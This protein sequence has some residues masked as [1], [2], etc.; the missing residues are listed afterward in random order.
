MY[1]VSY[2]GFTQWCA[3]VKQPPAL[4]AIVPFETWAEPTNGLAFRGGALELGVNA[5][6]G[7]QMG[8]D[9]LVRRHRSDSRALGPAIVALSK[10]I[11]QLATEGYSSL[12]LAE[13]GPF[14]RQPMLPR[15]FETVARPMDAELLIAL[16]SEHGPTSGYMQRIRESL[17]RDFPGSSFAHAG[18]GMFDVEKQ[19]Q[20]EASIQLVRDW[21][22][23]VWLGLGVVLALCAVAAAG[24]WC[25]ITTFV[26]AVITLW[27]FRQQGVGEL[28]LS[29]FRGRPLTPVTAPVRVASM[30][31]RLPR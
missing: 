16:K 10:E 11:D 26:I 31:A 30:R 1:G 7:L 21:F 29:V 2:F 5:S 20:Y 8:L 14:R 19:E 25:I 3:A 24:W 18:P 27:M 28:A 15:F 17:A 13:F 12:P 22:G 23:M 6:W 4:K 9:Q